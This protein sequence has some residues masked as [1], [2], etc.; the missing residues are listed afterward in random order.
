MP[1]HDLFE[2]E[3][4]L[5]RHEHS[6]WAV[7]RHGSDRCL[8]L[9][10]LGGHDAEV[11]LGQVGGIGDGV[12]VG[13]EVGL[14]RDAEPLGVEEVGLFPTAYQDPHLRLGCEMAGAQTPDGSGADHSDPLERHVVASRR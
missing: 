9:G 4:V 11:E 3:A 6:L 2:A 10:G 13:E 7:A 12:D 1:A 5:D 8:H 14:A